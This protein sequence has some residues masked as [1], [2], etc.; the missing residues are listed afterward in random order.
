MLFSRDIPF[1]SETLDVKHENGHLAHL[2]SFSGGGSHILLSIIEL[3]YLCGDQFA[4]FNGLDLH[5]KWG[6]EAK[7]FW[8]VDGAE[9]KTTK[10][11]TWNGKYEPLELL[12]ICSLC[13]LW[14]SRLCLHQSL[15]RT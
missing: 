15:V 11:L 3:I 5:S 2:D 1:C 4:I 6:A 14:Q 12:L 13:I 9:E 8:K 7:A 10:K